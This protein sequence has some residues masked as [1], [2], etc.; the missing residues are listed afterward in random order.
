[1]KNHAFIFSLL[2][3]TCYVVPAAAQ[4]TPT[5]AAAV[6]AGGSDDG[7]N[8]IIV[9][10]T[11]RETTLQDTPLAISALGSDALQQRNLTN[12]EALSGAVPNLSF[13]RYLGQARIGIRGLGND[14]STPTAEGR[15]A[16]HVDGIYVS[17]NSVAMGTLF[18]VERVEVVRGPQ[19]TLYGRNA[20]AGAINVIT[21]KP[22]DTAEGY[23]AAGFGNYN[24]RTVDFAI[25]GGIAPTLSARVALQYVNRDGWGTNEFTGN[26]IDD[27]NAYSGRL[28][29]RWQPSDAADVIV[30]ADHHRE[31]DSNYAAHYNGTSTEQTR[32]PYAL[33][34]TYGG[35]FAQDPRNINSERDPRNRRKTSGVAIDATFDLGARWTFKSLSGY[36]FSQY[37][38]DTDLD[39]TQISLAPYGQAERSNQYSQEFQLQYSSDRVEGVLGL[40]G[41]K[42]NAYGE[43]YILV[44]SGLVP[45]TFLTQGYRVAGDAKTRAGAAFGEFKFK[46]TDRLSLIAGGRFSAEKKSIVDNYQFRRDQPYTA[47]VNGPHLPGIP[48]LSAAGYPRSDSESWNSFTPKAGV[49]YQ[50]SDSLFLFAT[51]NNGFKSGGFSPGVNQPAFKPEK[52]ESFEIGERAKL[53]DGRLTLNAT[54]F[55][56]NYDDMQVSRV[57][58]TVVTVDNASS[59]KV[60]GI[61]VETVL[62]PL[63]GVRLDFSGSY[64]DTKFGDFFPVTGG[65]NVKG[66]RL[67]SAPRW[68]GLV[69]LTVERDL[70][71]TVHATLRGEAEYRSSQFFYPE[72]T[73]RFREPGRAKFNLFL[74][75]DLA[76]PDLTVSLY[77]RNLTDKLSWSAFRVGSPAYGA[78]VN[79]VIEAPRTFGIRIAKNF[80]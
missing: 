21:K 61:E 62:K 22:S 77:G 36:R 6:P 78:P 58:G 74:T 11:K 70:S 80:F 1:M 28:S 56:F 9:T 65:G 46:L 68:Q 51:Y 16:Y 41:F 60:A 5:Q 25:G 7:S 72:N 43:V 29:L 71:S 59:A 42:E 47:P 27:E 69:G 26:D 14:A 8:D 18:D 4:S 3:S 44:Q 40:Y 2:A 10:A 20:T 48:I 34:I 45:P 24:A 39:G 52:V 30:T 38:W 33:A 15:V 13:N 32:D 55:H 17:R 67:P 31:S 76:E 53:F 75:V 23:A 12:L 37:V 57:T 64:L 79:G 73:G 54:A 19:G 49:T 66:N 35:V 50:A 63:D